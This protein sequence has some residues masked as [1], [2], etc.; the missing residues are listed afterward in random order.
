MQRVSREDTLHEQQVTIPAGSVVLHGD[1]TLPE[2][3]GGMIVFAHGSGSGRRSP[4]NRS[5]AAFLHQARL[6]TLLVDLLSADEA[7]AD[8][9]TG[10][11]R[12]DIE[13]LA[14]RVRAAVDWLAS[15]PHTR[16]LP[17]GVYGA[18][19]GAAAALMAAAA[20]PR[21]V[22]AVVSRGGRPDL[23][24]NVLAQVTAP[25]LLVVGGADTLVL[26]LNREALAALRCPKR[27]EV[28]AGATHLF[29]EP[30]ALE[31]VSRLARDWFAHHLGGE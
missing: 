26:R 2:V 19:T 25:T 14:G 30:G 17:I 22:K 12:F 5:V 13:L 15:E 11:F 20:D 6:A 27:L 28:V 10:E 3:A 16:A 1:L 8:E 21:H 29:E 24:G 9:V 4:R 18:S 31:A 7:A 23:A